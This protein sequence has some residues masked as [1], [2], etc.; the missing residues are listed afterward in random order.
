[1]SARYRPEPTRPFEMTAEHWQR[2]QSLSESRRA[3]AL[4]RASI[5]HAETPGM[6]WEQADEIGLASVGVGTQKA[7]VGT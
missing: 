1:M 3:E 5:V 2:L 7:L 4:E 6:T